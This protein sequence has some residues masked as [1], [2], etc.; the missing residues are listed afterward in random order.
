MQKRG[1]EQS[2]AVFQAEAQIKEPNM[3][4]DVPSGFL[5]E[6]W[7]VFWDIFSARFS[8]ATN[9]EAFNYLEV[10]C[11]LLK[12]VQLKQDFER[13]QRAMQ[14]QMMQQYQKASNIPPSNAAFNGNIGMLLILCNR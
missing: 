14:Q 5:H 1:Y 12:A 9:K 10:I 3:P 2:A 8:N 6:W 4:V 13:K 11:F 7:S